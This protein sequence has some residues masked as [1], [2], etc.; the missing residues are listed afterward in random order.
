M[1]QIDELEILQFEN[2]QLVPASVWIPHL[3]AGGP[4]GRQQE[5]GACPLVSSTGHSPGHLTPRSVASSL[6]SIPELWPMSIRLGAGP[7]P[8]GWV[9]PACAS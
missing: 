4:W 1:F 8:L 5:G 2:P 3:E 6:C 9:G 7:M